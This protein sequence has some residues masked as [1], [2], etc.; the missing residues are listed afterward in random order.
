ML[1]LIVLVLIVLNVGFYARGQ[2]WLMAYGWGPTP[3]R[4]PQRLAQQ[5]HP[6]ALLIVPGAA[7]SAPVAPAAPEAREVAAEPQVP[8]PAA[9]APAAPTS[10]PDPKTAASAPQTTACWQMADIEPAQADALR[11]LL[12]LNF[13]EAVWVLDELG[14]PERWMV[15]MGKYTNPDELAKKREQLTE[16]K[17]NFSV[18][19]S[20]AWGPGVSLGVFNSQEGAS[21][22]LQELVRRGVR[23]A[24]VVRERPSSQH[25]RLR[26]PTIRP[27]NQP[28]LDAI[29]AALP[30]KTLELCPAASPASA[31]LAAR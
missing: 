20:A 8:T 9:S 7:A 3:Q 14:L 12:R 25:Y 16:L 15:Y 27:P 21:T 10:A 2:G 17:V 22:T 23:S 13:P 28:V 11:A 24:R 1:R 31:A 4:E 19:T 26:L 6:E 18:I 5:I 30:G 29:K